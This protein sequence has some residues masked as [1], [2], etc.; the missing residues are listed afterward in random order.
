MTRVPFRTAFFSSA[1]VL[2]LA[3]AASFA[4]ARE[5]KTPLG[6]WMKP[7]MGTALAGQDFDTLQ[8]SADLVASKPPAGGNYPKWATMAKAVSAAAAKQD[9]KALK[10]ACKD[11]HDAYEDK[12]IKD[13]PSQPFP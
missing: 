3:L 10:A 1:L 8:K 11:C 6:K 5:A 12:Y 13:F 9:V 7:N 2:S 4:A